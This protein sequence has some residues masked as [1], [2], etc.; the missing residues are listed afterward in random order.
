MRGADSLRTFLKGHAFRREACPLFFA[1]H[2]RRA[3]NPLLL[4]LHSAANALWRKGGVLFQCL[5]FEIYFTRWGCVSGGTR[6]S[7]E[8][9]AP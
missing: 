9:T 8:V 7:P 3:G 4:E 6:A 5:L 1:G 2:T